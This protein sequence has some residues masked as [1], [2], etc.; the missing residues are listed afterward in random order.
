MECLSGIIRV[1]TESHIEALDDIRKDRCVAERIALGD[2]D[3]FGRIA[4]LQTYERQAVDDRLELGFIA[5]DDSSG[6]AFA[7]VGLL[8]P[9]SGKSGFGMSG[10]DADGSDGALS[11]PFGSGQ[12]VGQR[13][14]VLTDEGERLGV[15]VEILDIIPEEQC[16]AFVLQAL[17]QLALD[18]QQVVESDEAVHPACG[19]RT[20]FVPMGDDVAHTLSLIA[21]AGLFQLIAQ[22]VV[23]LRHS[24]PE[25]SE[26]RLYG[27]GY[28]RLPACLTLV[29]QV[30]ESAADIL[31]KM[32]SIQIRQGE[33]VA[34][35]RVDLRRADALVDIREVRQQLSS[36]AVEAVNVHRLLIADR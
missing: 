33:C 27:L 24:V 36:P 6:F 12:R 16:S 14:H 29:E 2:I 30:F 21:L 32:V 18:G 31:V 25:G 7:F 10:S 28:K 8:H 17:H 11:A 26:V 5:D 35:E 20:E 23:Y 13:E 19:T 1:L 3:L 22:V 15:G 9:P 34:E 4:T